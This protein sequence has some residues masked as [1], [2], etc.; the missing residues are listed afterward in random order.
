M[1]TN[2]KI[3]VWSKP[4]CHY[5]AEVKSYLEANHY[6]YENIDVG[7][8]DNLRDVLE[9]KYGIRHVPVVEIGRDGKFEGVVE[10]GL[11]HLQAALERSLRTVV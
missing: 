5:C 2:P 10:L 3:V 8:N 6:S 7:A 11:D 4:G 1:S 9:V